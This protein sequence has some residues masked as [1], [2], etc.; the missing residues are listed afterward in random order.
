MREKKET[1]TGGITRDK[2]KKRNTIAFMIFQKKIDE[3]H[4]GVHT[5]KHCSCT[6]G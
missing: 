2:K 1:Q 5:N 4:D 3:R 6:A